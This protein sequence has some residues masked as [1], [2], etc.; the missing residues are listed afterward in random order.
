ML[1]VYG[2]VY[3]HAHHLVSCFISR[4]IYCATGAFWWVK[5]TWCLIDPA[6]ALT[7]GILSGFQPLSAQHLV[8]LRMD[9]TRI[10]PSASKPISSFPCHGWWRNL[11]TS[12]KAR[13]SASSATRN[14]EDSRGTARV[15]VRARPLSSRPFISLPLVWTSSSHRR[16]AALLLLITRYLLF[17]LLWSCLAL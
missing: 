2:Q 4:F 6:R 13:S 9:P 12:W 14:S 3:F 7:G 1:Q 8:H 15:L 16:I 10:S 17:A 11:V 5:T